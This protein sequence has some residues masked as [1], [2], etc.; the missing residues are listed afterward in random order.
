MEKNLN[1]ETVEKRRELNKILSSSKNFADIVSGL[2]M[3]MRLQNELIISEFRELN[4]A[5]L[6]LNT[7][8]DRIIDRL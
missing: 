7:R 8:I 1:D 3:D 5:I 2:L 6:L 4:S